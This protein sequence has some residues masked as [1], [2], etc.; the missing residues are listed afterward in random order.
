[1]LFSYLFDNVF[2]GFNIFKVLL[3]NLHDFTIKSQYGLLIF[4]LFYGFNLLDDV[5]LLIV[6]ESGLDNF[7]IEAIAV[8]G[9]IVVS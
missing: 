9:I 8:V 1:L 5:F 2:I 7:T 3:A 6:G 4:L